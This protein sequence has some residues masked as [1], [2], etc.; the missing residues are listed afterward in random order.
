MRDAVHDDQGR[1]APQAVL[2]DAVP[3][4]GVARGEA[5]RANERGLTM[6]TNGADTARK[7]K[8]RAAGEGTL[9]YSEGKGLWIGRLRVAQDAIQAVR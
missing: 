5:R 6:A 2:L 1:A 3:G 7:K 9:R 4:A 8:H